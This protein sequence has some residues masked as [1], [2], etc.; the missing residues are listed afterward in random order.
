MPTTWAL[1]PSN[2][3][4]S[5]WKAATS[6]VQVGVKAP[7]NPK[8]TT[9]FLPWNSLIENF[10]F[11]VA[12][13]VKSGAGSP[14]WSAPAGTL[15]TSRTAASTKSVRNRLMG[16]LLW[17]VGPLSLEQRLDELERFLAIPLPG[18]DRPADDRA[19]A[20]DDHRDRDPADAVLLGHGHARIEQRRYLVAVPVHV[21]LHVFFAAPVEGHEVH[22][23]VFGEPSLEVFQA[24]ELRRAG[25]APG[26]AEGED[27]ELS[28]ERGRGHGL[29]RQ[30]GELEG[31]GRA[32][33]GFANEE[34]GRILGG[35]EACGES[36]QDGSG[37]GHAPHHRQSDTATG[38][39]ACQARP[40]R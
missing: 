25:G 3:G 19:L 20:V 10:S 23:Q 5:N 27:G 11:V 22:R 4:R 8:S 29:A 17:R 18:A 21:R 30:I 39:Q 7:M 32:R 9:F 36:Q 35:A 2:L 14:T 40:P 24:L 28:P 31:G 1:R 38:S 34:N 33:L 6:R 26:G 37:D 15:R 13:S 12:G 16:C